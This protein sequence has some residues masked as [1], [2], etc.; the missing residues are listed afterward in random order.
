MWEAGS[1]PSV[2]RGGGTG[3]R[4]PQEELAGGGEAMELQFLERERIRFERR[5]ERCGSGSSCAGSRSSYASGRNTT[6][7]PW[8]SRGQV[9]EVV[10]HRFSTDGASKSIGANH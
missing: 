4:D 1:H 9:V 7:R 10:Y 3:A 2:P 8:R 5:R 6:P